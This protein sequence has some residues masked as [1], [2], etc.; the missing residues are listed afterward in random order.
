[1]RAWFVA[2]A[3]TIWIIVVTASI[4]LFAGVGLCYLPGDPSLRNKFVCST[5]GTTAYFDV[6]T[7]VVG[8]PF[9]ILIDH[10]ARNPSW[11]EKPLSTRIL[12]LWIT[13]TVI[14]VL[15]F[16]SA[17]VPAGLPSF[18]LVLWLGIG[19]L[20]AILFIVGAEIHRSPRKTGQLYAYTWRGSN[21]SHEEGDSNDTSARKV[22]LPV[23]T[24]AQNGNVRRLP[25][26]DVGTICGYQTRY[27]R[28]IRNCI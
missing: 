22:S 28:T 13:L 9:L 2:L 8:V 11:L 1:M 25:A 14:I 18:L 19:L 16:V 10:V 17:L 24:P 6:I 15:L 21:W 23:T 27:Q 7:L 26:S 20:C 5:V 3:A 12:Y 4:L